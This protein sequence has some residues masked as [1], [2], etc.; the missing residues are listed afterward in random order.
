MQRSCVILRQLATMS[1]NINLIGN[2]GKKLDRIKDFQF[3]PYET[4]AISVGLDYFK[5]R[6]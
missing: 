2:N 5:F 4:K 6:F 1:S 3:N